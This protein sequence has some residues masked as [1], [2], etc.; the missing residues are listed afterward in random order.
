MA[1]MRIQL[2]TLFAC[3]ITVAIVALAQ[4]TLLISQTN[5][6]QNPSFEG[7][8]TARFDPCDKRIASELGTPDG[9]DPYFRCRAQ[10]DP[11]FTNF[12]PEFGTIRAADFAYRV[13]SGATAL[14]YFNFYARNEAAGVSQRVSVPPNAWLRFSIWSQLWT[15]ACDASQLPNDKP[16]SRYYPG[17]L[18]ARVCIDT[19]GGALDFD[20]GTLCSEWMRERAWDQYAQ[21]FVIAQ[22]VGSEVTVALNTRAQWPVKHN[23]AY[24]DDAELL[25]VAA[26]LT[27]TI[28]GPNIRRIW[29]P[30]VY[31]ESFAPLPEPEPIPTCPKPG[32][33]R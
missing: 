21:A 10:T 18:E 5:L 7:A 20:S 14:K 2:Q 15:S 33:L 32:A 9:W 28:P 29:A 13:H 19:D 1:S 24:A 26:P 6:L 12:R 27:A 4:P 16:S 25:V 23:D 11:P 17:N 30:A 8:T 31:S 22:A 3:S